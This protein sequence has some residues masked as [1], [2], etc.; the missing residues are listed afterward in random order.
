MK[1]SIRFKLLT[2]GIVSVISSALSVLSVSLNEHQTLYANSVKESLVALTENT[3][4]DILLIMS[5]NNDSFLLRSALLRF[6]RYEHIEYAILYDQNW[7]QIEIYLKPSLINKFEKELITITSK[8]PKN[9]PLGVSV[10]ENSFYALQ[11]IGENKFLQGYLLVT[12]EY[13]NPIEKSQKELLKLT[14]PLIFIILAVA[15]SATLF[16]IRQQLFPLLKL[17]VFTR[18]ISRSKNYSK[19]FTVKGSDEVSTLASSINTLLE[20]INHEIKENQEKNNQLTEQ[21]E[22]MYRLANYDQLTGLPNRR[23]V[24]TLLHELLQKHSAL[25]QLVALLYFDIDY[26]KSINDRMGHEVGDKL[27]VE[28]GRTVTKLLEKDQILARL[29]GDEFLIIIPNPPSKQVLFNITEKLTTAFNTPLV[30][31]KWSI[32]TGISIGV[33]DTHDA[34]YKVNDLIS[35]AD[36]AMYHS[37]NFKK[38]TATFFNSQMLIES[39]RHT[40]IVNGIIDAVRDNEFQLYYQPKISNQGIVEGLEALIRWESKTLGSLSPSEFIPIAETSGKISDITKWVIDQVLDDLPRLLEY[41]NKNIVI[42]FNI[43]SYDLISGWL[44]DYIRQLISVRP[45]ALQHLQFEITESSYLNDFDQANRLFSMVQEAGGSVALDDFG[46]GFS[47]LSYLSRIDIDTIKVD[48]AFIDNFI[49]D[50]REK[51]VL[52]SILELS[53]QLG[54]NICCEGVENIEQAKYLIVKKCHLMQGF[55]FSAPTPI[56]EL[57]I[58]VDQAQQRYQALGLF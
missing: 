40:L 20:V 27:L 12:H 24:M 29:A 52:N 49:N 31:E 45:N 33:S 21:K 14:L 38:G 18:H 23:H 19:R 17:T 4:D 32:Q 25:D 42:S 2:I 44:E 41:S 53:D 56:E 7:N 48:R 8:A 39:Q 28:V 37:K 13:S 36:I 11:E 30:I 58:A 22:A 6:E 57:S 43:S 47:S 34:G 16:T 9:L 26:F 15:I 35:Y 51:A 10:L 54:L 50:Y 55:Y 3:A 5:D 46:T 1:L